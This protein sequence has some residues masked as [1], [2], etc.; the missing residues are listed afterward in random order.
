MAERMKAAIDTNG[1]KSAVIDG[2][3]FV[4]KMTISALGSRAPD[5]AL[6]IVGLAPVPRRRIPDASGGGTRV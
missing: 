6:A 3:S 5:R 4:S 1:L 2:Q